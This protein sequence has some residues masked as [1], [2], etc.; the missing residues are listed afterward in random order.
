MKRGV[1]F[2]ILALAC[3]ALQQ[4]WVVTVAQTERPR[5]AIGNAGTME[6]TESGTAGGVWSPALTGE[7]RPLYRVTTSD[8]LELTFTFSP[9]YNQTVT[10]QPD[11]F[12]VLRDVGALYAEGANLPHLRDLIRIAYSSLLNDPQVTLVLKQFDK[13]YFIAAGEVTR[14]GKYD[15]RGDTTVTE[16]V[17]MAGGFNLQAKHSQVVLFRRMS[18]QKVE[19]RVVDVK[20]MMSVRSLNEDIH[21]KPGDLVFVPQNAISKWRK[22]LPG[23]SLSLYLNPTQ[24]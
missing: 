23:S 1:S 19:T 24:F 8:I 15:L 14:P 10:V 18:D 7:R 16:A 21:L 20:R 5:V 2:T 13:P 6:T 22:F 17:A 12:I 3:C 11:G 4:A 9:E